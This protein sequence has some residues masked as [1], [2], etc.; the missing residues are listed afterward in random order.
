MMVAA[1][2]AEAQINNVKQLSK[3][4]YATAPGSSVR[5]GVLRQGK[6]SSVKV[7]LGQMPSRQAAGLQPRNGNRQQRQSCAT[8]LDRLLRLFDH[9][10][11]NCGL[12]GGASA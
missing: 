1:G 7:T 2:L 12:R 9:P 4:I 3:Q 6:Q 5:L 11:L 10:G 8:G